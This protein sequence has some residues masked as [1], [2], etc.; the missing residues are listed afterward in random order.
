M[1]DVIGWLLEGPAFVQYRARLDLLG[2]TEKNKDVVAA[3]RAML[4]DPQVQALVAE[5]AAWP[6]RVLS[7]H[8]SAGH[9]L[10][11]LV[12]LS[13]LGLRATDPGMKVVVHAVMKHQAEQGPFQVL[14]NVP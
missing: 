2:Q 6:V 8:K 4:A 13:D 3:R 10:H 5:L 7:G 1:A 9:P 11:K 12:F 14:A